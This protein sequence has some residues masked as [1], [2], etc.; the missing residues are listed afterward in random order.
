[1]KKIFPIFIYLAAILC[2]VSCNDFLDQLPDNRTTLD[3]EDKV[4]RMLTSCYPEVTFAMFTEYMSDNADD[5]GKTNPHT[6]RFFDQIWHWEDIT[7][8]N[9]DSP[10]NFW[11]SAYSALA[12]ANEALAAIETL[13]AEGQG[14]AFLS[15]CKAEA[16]LCRAYEAFMLVNIFSLNYNSATASSDPGVPFPIAPQDGANSITDRGTVAGVYEQIDKDL[17]E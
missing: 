9:N 2:A 11:N 1:M 8:D 12:G 14:S 16:L 5:N 6:D 3:S 13:E 17:R 7:E 10:E 4:A 15:E